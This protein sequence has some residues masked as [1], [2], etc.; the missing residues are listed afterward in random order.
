[1]DPDQR[2]LLGCYRQ[3]KPL[4]KDDQCSHACLDLH[5]HPQHVQHKLQARDMPPASLFLLLLNVR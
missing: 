4:R 1:M 3:L 2:F 5:V